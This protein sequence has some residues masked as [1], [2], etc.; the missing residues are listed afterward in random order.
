MDAL[1]SKKRRLEALRKRKEELRRKKAE[2]K[3]KEKGEVPQMSP[4]KGQNPE[5][6]EQAKEEEEPKGPRIEMSTFVG[7]LNIRGKQATYKY[8]R[9][10]AVTKEDIKLMEMLQEE[11]EAPVYDYEAE[12]EG[13]EDEEQLEGDEKNVFKAKRV[14][15][16]EVEKIFKNP[17]FRRFVRRGSADLTDALDDTYTLIEDVLENEN[18]EIA[19]DLRERI[20]KGVGYVEEALLENHMCNDLQWCRTHAEWFLGIYNAM[21]H[22]EHI[23]KVV[24]WDI[25]AK[26]KPS[27]VHTLLSTKKVNRAVFN[28]KDENIIYGGLS[29]GQVVVWDL[30]VRS[31]PIMKTKPTLA[32]HNLPIFCLEVVNDGRR[33]MLLSISYE[34]R[35]CLWNPTTLAEPEMIE[36]LRFKTSAGRA[37]E[38]DTDNPLAPMISITVPGITSKDT[39]LILGTYD[40]IIQRYKVE[41]I[42][43]RAEERIVDRYEAH[44]APVCTLSY[45][46]NPGNKILDGLLLSG[47]FDF[48]I[49]LWKPNRNEERIL[50]LEI[51]EDYITAVDWNPVHPALFVSSDC[52]GK[53]CVWDLMEDKDYPVYI[54]Q[55][56][57]I[58]C[59]KWH[60]DGLKLIVGTLKGEVYMWNFKKR[61][62]KVIEAQQKEFEQFIEGN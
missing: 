3:A 18:P 9:G 61:F 17:S 47:S 37:T 29:S 16:K 30:R 35:L 23:G 34:G 56:D 46:Q 10:I 21:S 42:L 13:E 40:K 54:T 15:E 59:L 5:E 57:P 2:R 32:N 25:E 50:C 45:K 27:P 11:E 14:P 8:D 33:D 20:T 26:G 39:N 49:N 62:L 31:T 60:P 24:I 38:R 7:V 52:T 19:Q 22:E 4:V 1:E 55:T 58:S 28:P 48:T 41:D 6:K 43:S 51:H 44:N 53:I 12:E 36:D